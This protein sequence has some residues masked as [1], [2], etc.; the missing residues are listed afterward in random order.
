MKT[1]KLKALGACDDAVEFAA[2]H[3]TYQE[4][5]EKNTRVDWAMWL[6]AHA[7]EE[8][9]LIAVGL[10]A[11][12][13]ERVL[14]HVP[15]GSR[16]VC[17]EAIEAARAYARDPSDKNKGRCRITADAAYAAYAY[18]YAAAAAYAAA[19]AADAADAAADAAAYAAAR[20]AEQQWQMARILEVC[21]RCP[22]SEEG[23]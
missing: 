2:T 6:L 4:G 22:I 19:N 3:D 9:R 14:Q 5:W 13:A 12:F 16:R 1:T 11:D 20:E 8:S 10:A 21:P 18:A 23:E 15:E 7:S 17:V